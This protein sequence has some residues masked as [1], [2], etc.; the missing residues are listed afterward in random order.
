MRIQSYR[1]R[2]GSRARRHRVGSEGA[3]HTG[4]GL[5]QD[6]RNLLPTASCALEGRSLLQV[7]VLP[8]ST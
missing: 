3:Q 5:E 7:D 8:K 1:R 6:E 4:C 2:L